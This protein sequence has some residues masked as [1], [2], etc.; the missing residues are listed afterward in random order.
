MNFCSVWLEY[1]NKYF[2]APWYYKY[3]NKFKFFNK[4]S[5]KACNY[6]EE[7]LFTKTNMYTNDRVIMSH[8][9]QEYI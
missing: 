4:A 6:K 8:S 7:Y 1:L 2:V 9:Q 5:N 3:F